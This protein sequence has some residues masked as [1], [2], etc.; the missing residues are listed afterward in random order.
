MGKHGSVGMLGLDLLKLLS[1]DCGVDG[2]AAVVD[3]NLLFGYLF[4]NETAQIAV[5]DKEY[6]L[7]RQGSDDGNG[8]GGGDANVA[9]RFELSRGIDIADNGKV[10]KS[11][12]HFLY[13]SRRDHMR[14]RAIGLEVGHQ[15]LF[16][17]IEDLGTFAH[18]GHAAK[19]DNI[20]RAFFGRLGK[21][22][23]V[24]HKIRNLLHLGRGVIM[25]KYYRIF[26]SF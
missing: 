26:L 7:I 20:R 11:A 24:A 2:T 10:V 21:I 5:G 4:G 16:V 19:N 12:S 22:K 23:G 1:G 6:V 17:R 18:K 25:G 14:H 13:L 15:H 8:V 3:H 9:L